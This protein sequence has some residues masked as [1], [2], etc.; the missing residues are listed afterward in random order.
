MKQSSKTIIL[1]FETTT[2]TNEKTDEINRMHNAKIKIFVTSKSSSSNK[3]QIE[4][5]DHFLINSVAVNASNK[6]KFAFKS[7]LKLSKVI[8]FTK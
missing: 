8:D 7:S 6:K 5:F 1:K 3:T 2:L 4:K